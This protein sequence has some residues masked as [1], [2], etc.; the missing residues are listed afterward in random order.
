MNSVNAWPPVPTPFV[1]G[2]KEAG[3]ANESEDVQALV[4]VFTSHA[5]T[6]EQRHSHAEAPIRCRELR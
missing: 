5:R 3:E 1:R 4:G 6:Y 2:Q